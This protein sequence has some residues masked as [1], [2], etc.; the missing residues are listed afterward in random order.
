MIAG[1]VFGIDASRSKNVA[2]VHGA[3]LRRRPLPLN[4]GGVLID[5]E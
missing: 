4:D 1:H 5:S 2:Q 3:A